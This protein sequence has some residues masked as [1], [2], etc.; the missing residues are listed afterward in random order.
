MSHPGAGRSGRK[1]HTAVLYTRIDLFGHASLH[2]VGKHLRV[3]D[4]MQGADPILAFGL[5]STPSRQ[6]MVNSTVKGPLPTTQVS[7]HYPDSAH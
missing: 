6:S 3:S 1:G 7:D 2:S 5:S 4:S